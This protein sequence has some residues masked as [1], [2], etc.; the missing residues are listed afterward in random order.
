VALPNPPRPAR[1]LTVHVTH[2]PPAPVLRYID[3]VVGQE[4]AGIEFRFSQSV[5]TSFDPDV[6]HVLDSDLDLL[7]GTKDAAGVARLLAALAF[8]WNIKRHR[9]ALV[10]TVHELTPLPTST[11]AD[12]LTARVIDRS[13]TRYV[14][15]DTET[16][17]ASANR[18]V[19]IPEAEYSERF[20]GYPRSAQVPGRVVCVSAGYV[21]AAAKRLLGA[22]RVASTPGLTIRLAGLASRQIAPHIQSAVAKHPALVSSRIE[23]LSDSA[24]VM[25]ISAAEL[26]AVPRVETLED[27]RLIWLA[28]SLHRPVITPSIGFID[29]IASSVGRAWIHQ[30]DGEITP[31]DIDKALVTSRSL[32]PEDRPRLEGRE[33]STSHRQFARVFEESRRRR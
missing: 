15:M 12:R 5:L 31:A 3:S 28:L 13:T 29:R 32:G 30:C 7:L 11:W 23:R 21:P 6:V 24:Q 26:V 9:I 27:V 33:L 10:R 19:V 4:D 16:A 22:P 18:T 17:T 1:P 20:E 25:E 8:A 14:T 2:R